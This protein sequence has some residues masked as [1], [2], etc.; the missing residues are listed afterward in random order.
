MPQSTK[1]APLLISVLVLG[2]L[3]ACGLLLDDEARLERA[4]QAYAAGDVAGAVVD[5]KT[6]LQETPDNIDARLLLGETLVKAG[7]L[8]AARSEFGRS[9]EFLRAAIGSGTG[10]RPNAARELV[11]A[12]GKLA[13]LQLTLGEYAPA[14]TNA[15]FV[16]TEDPSNVTAY[17]IASQS[18]YN[19]GD[20][21]KAR[22]HASRLMERSPE[23]PLAHAMLGF[24]DAREGAHAE[25]EAHFV[26]VLAQRPDQ[27]AVRLTLTQ[28]QIA[29]A[30][31]EAA[32]AT[33]APL[34]VA[35]PTDT[36]LLQ[37][38]DV[39]QLGSPAARA[40]VDAVAQGI[41]TSNATSPV[42]GILRGRSLLLTREFQAAAAQFQSAIA[43][44][45]GRYPLVGYYVAQRAAGDQGAAQ[46]ALE[47]WV[48]ANPADQDTGFLLA[49]AYLEQGESDRAR[50]LYER[51]VGTADIDSPAI[52]NN[53][54]WLYGE[55]SD[56]RAI[57][58][59]RQA[60]QEAPNNGAIT[61]T[62]G[63]LLVKA[64]EVDEGIQMLRLAVQQLP[65][66]EEVRSHLDAALVEAGDKDAAQRRIERILPGSLDV[67]PPGSAADGPR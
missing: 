43:N 62:L 66:S 57:E 59:A 34:L 26:A 36:Q 5:L 20:N 65:D 31:H 19:L 48:E 18:A 32:V 16:V 46:Q 28:I 24:V 8:E 53:L 7:D 22:A 33:L 49:A 13:S 61:D 38:L 56:P 11:E 3:S 40:S 6:L 51:L 44:G 12:A 4:R 64:G 17:V 55:I 42:P 52:L 37:I 10:A 41:E 58:T 54:A 21:A 47:Q 63:W 29:M 35:V 9:V 39:L 1:F 60:H 25:A 27:H 67:P 50:T 15:E 23:N 14:L 2:A 45:G 30:K